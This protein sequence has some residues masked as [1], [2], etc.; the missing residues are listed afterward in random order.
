MAASCEAEVTHFGAHLPMQRRASHLA[1][2]Q[3]ERKMHIRIRQI[4]FALALV[5][6]LS[7][8]GYGQSSKP[9]TGSKAKHSAAQTSSSD[10]SSKISMSDKRFLKKAAEGNEAEV[11]L[12]KLAQEKSQD[13]KVKEFGQRMVT[14]HSKAN[15]KLQSLASSKGVELPSEPGL[16]AK[17]E[18]KRLA[19]L[20]GEKF[21][22]AYMDYMVKEHTNDVKEF[23]KESE[24][25]KDPEVKSFASST[26]L[27][28][29]EHLK[30]AQSIAPKEHAE[31]RAAKRK[32]DK[33]STSASNP[34]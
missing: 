19:R 1:S 2:T 33:T 8:L 24:S 15:E 29:Q 5:L 28:L 30:Q 27:T 23:Q 26:L 6:A 17:T 21:D 20:D 18:E 22:K 25:A 14:D 7:L 3:E 10:S 32:A 4:S 34:R 9:D 12:G 31:A 16:M 11:E 13:P